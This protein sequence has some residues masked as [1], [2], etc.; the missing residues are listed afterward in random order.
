[1]KIREDKE[2][3]WSASYGKPHLT[4]GTWFMHGSCGMMPFQ[5]EVR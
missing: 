1:M 2:K 3:R 5:D 4:L